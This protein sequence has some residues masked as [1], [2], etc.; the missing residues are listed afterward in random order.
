MEDHLYN[1]DINLDYMVI[2]EYILSSR[3]SKFKSSTVEEWNN[4]L[5]KDFSSFT[6]NMTFDFSKYQDKINIMIYEL[7]YFENML[8]EENVGEKAEIIYYLVNHIKELK[9]MNY[10][11]EDELFQEVYNHFHLIMR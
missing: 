1:L 8:I 10:I 6:A 2:N 4:E 5:I 3:P 7:S 9:D 11:S